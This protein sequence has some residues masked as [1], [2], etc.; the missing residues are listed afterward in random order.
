MSHSQATQNSYTIPQ[1]SEYYTPEN[2]GTSSN[3]HDHLIQSNL[4][5]PQQLAI[6]KEEQQISGTSLRAVILKMG[7]LT[8]ETLMAWLGQELSYE[9]YCPENY[10][11]DA[12]DAS[13]YE[14]KEED[15][16]GLRAVPL[17]FQENNREL[18]VALADVLDVTRQDSLKRLYPH[19]RS[20][21]ILI[22]R[23]KDIIRTLD[24]LYTA[25][26]SSPQYQGG[27]SERGSNI[28][29][30][31]QEPDTKP[32][33]DA[34]EF[35]EKTLESA[36]K[37]QA[38]DI[39]FAPEELF[40]RVRLRIDGILS[41]HHLFHKSQWGAILSRLKIL[42]HMNIAE[43]RLPQSGRFSQQIAGRTIDFRT[44]AHPTANGENFVLRS[45]DRLHTFFELPDLGFSPEHID[46]LKHQLNQ[47]YGI[48]VITG[49]TGSGKTTTLYSMLSYL[50][51]KERNIMTLEDPIEYEMHNIRQTQVQPDIGFDFPQGV[52]SILRQDPDV[53][54]IGEIRDEETAKMALRAA[55]TGHLVLTTLH[56]NSALL[57]VN[58][59]V[60][61]GVDA[62]LLSGNINCILSQRLVRKPLSKTRG[63]Q[64]GRRPLAEILNV[65]PELDSLF[66]QKA[67]Y[68]ELLTTARQQGFRT[69][70]E[71]AKSLLKTKELALENIQDVL[72][73]DEIMS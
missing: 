59:L 50:R 31:A 71:Q 32:Q 35:I 53:I 67:P 28:T 45:L 66:T 69:M 38:S 73:Y 12:I 20:L 22:A 13:L 72:A 61:L 18:T 33:L 70:Q 47:P 21:K 43:T 14:H 60:D 36:V 56:T 46:H 34:T 51:S 8:E 48:I 54:L 39:H 40:V 68:H 41:D 30:L 19:A 58:R 23:E 25:P 55:M 10:T 17:S 16:Y 49:P 27:L 7:F 5:T 11:L 3:Y 29:Y 65:S 26:S 24:T 42:S 52:R 63:N 6:A 15:L 62:S 64:L 9:V 44:S 2:H 4:L 37:Q 1:E 57:A